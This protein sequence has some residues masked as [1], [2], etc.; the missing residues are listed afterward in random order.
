MQHRF[1][2][3]LNEFGFADGASVQRRRCAAPQPLARAD[4]AQDRVLNPDV[5]TTLSLEQA[6]SWPK[7]VDTGC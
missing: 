1:F 2:L 5:V 4:M 3:T 6:S 7:M